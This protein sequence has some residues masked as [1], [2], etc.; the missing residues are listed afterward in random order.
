MSKSIAVPGD[1]EARVIDTLRSKGLLNSPNTRRRVAFTA[2]AAVLI[3]AVGIGTGRASFAYHSRVGETER[4]VL[5][6]Y[7]DA[8]ADG[9]SSDVTAHKRWAADV[10]ANG[11]EISGEKLAPG[12]TVLS[13]EN[14][15]VSTDAGG[16][17]RGFFIISAK[18]ASE[19]ASIAR[20]SPHFLHGGK[21][22][23]RTIDPT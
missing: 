15:S 19:A 4:F 3:F 8:T 7:G 9:A 20:S 5:L 23:L 22:V 16:Q 13:P 12:E 6:L 1:L 14:R 17:L 21:V 11:H 18:S 2:A 10:A